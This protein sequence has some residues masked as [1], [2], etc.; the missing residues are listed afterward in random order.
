MIKKIINLC[1]DINKL[2]SKNFEGIGLVIYSDIK[3]LPVASMNTEKATYDLPI[4]NYDDILKT[5]IEISSSNSK[6]QDGF[7]LLSKEFKLTHISQYFST[8]IIKNLI[9]T[10]IFGSRYRT[11]LYGSCLPNVLFTAVISKNYGL[12]IFENGKEIYVDKQTSN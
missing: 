4:S 12:I 2:K 11:A 6:F 10:N 9:V 1:N 7:H 3:E 8:P 5:L